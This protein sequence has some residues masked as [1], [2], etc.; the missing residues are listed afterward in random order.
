MSGCDWILKTCAMRI[1]GFTPRRADAATAVRL[2]FPA[3]R[4]IDNP[5]MRVGTSETHERLCPLISQAQ[6]SLNLL[7]SFVF[8]LSAML[9][10]LQ[11]TREGQS[12]RTTAAHEYTYYSSFL[13]CFLYFS[14]TIHWDGIPPHAKFDRS[15]TKW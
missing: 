11:K 10:K 5:I 7:A 3:P 1:P 2:S 6:A 4:D 9:L 13:P 12:W 15:F 14:L 8:S